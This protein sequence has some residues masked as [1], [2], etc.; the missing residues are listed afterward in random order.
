MEY[1]IV[2]E[3]ATEKV[4]GQGHTQLELANALVAGVPET[5]NNCPTDNIPSN[6]GTRQSPKETTSNDS[7]AVQSCNPFS[8]E[9]E[10][11][12]QKQE[13]PPEHSEYL[14]YK[15]DEI[16]QSKSRTEESVTG[17]EN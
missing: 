12:N 14:E 17:Q 4:L 11:V 9:S 1:W 15:A 16:C 13:V 2:E 7:G 8:F 3:A 10:G 6:L 5:P